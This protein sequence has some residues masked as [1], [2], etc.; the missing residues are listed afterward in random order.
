MVTSQKT[1]LVVDDEQIMLTV[2]S[3]ILGDE[4]GEVIKILTASSGTQARKIIIQQKVDLLLIDLCLAGESGI[5]L[6]IWAK[7]QQPELK[8]IVFTGFGT[9]ESCRQAFKAQISDY[10]LKPFKPAELIKVIKPLL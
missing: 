2:C 7:N 5:D 3:D 6:W 4:F 9:I 10:F 8:G 1:I